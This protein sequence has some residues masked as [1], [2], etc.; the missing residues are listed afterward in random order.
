MSNPDNIVV[1]EPRFFSS[2]DETAFFEWLQRI[3]GITSIIGSSAGLSADIEKTSFDDNSLRE[4]IAL[5]HRYDLDFNDIEV[6][7]TQGNKDWVYDPETYWAV[8]FKK[9][10]A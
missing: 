5:Y 3:P 4:L 9:R 2:L 6:L 7:V 8:H 10:Q 1:K